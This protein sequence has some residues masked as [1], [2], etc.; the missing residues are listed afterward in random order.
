MSY[1]LASLRKLRDAEV[2]ARLA[3]LAN[4]TQ[5]E[6]R[7]ARDLDGLVQQ[8][9]AHVA[10]TARVER[11]EGDPRGAISVDALA[12]LGEWRRRRRAEAEA[13]AAALER[14]R[15]ALDGARTETAAARDA[16]AHARAE[17]EALARHEARWRAEAGRHAERRTEAEVE[18]LVQASVVRSRS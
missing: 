7:C 17:V 1:P 10:E 12:R 11:D 14:A 4:A 8:R 13:L 15:A 18:D 9:D 16:V 6:E 2:D 5:R 3:A